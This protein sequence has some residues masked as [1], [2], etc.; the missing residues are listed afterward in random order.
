PGSRKQ[1]TRDIGTRAGVSRPRP[2]DQ[3][4]V[5]E[6]DFGAAGAGP[7]A[8]G[9]GRHAD[10]QARGRRVRHPGRKRGGLR[11]VHQPRA[12]GS[13][14]RERPQPVVRERQPAQGRR[15][16]R[17]ADRRT[18][19][20][21]TPQERLTVR[22][23]ALVALA[24]TLAACNRSDP[25]P[26]AVGTEDAAPSPSPVATDGAAGVN[27][28]SEVALALDAEGLRFV[29]N[30]TGSA[31]LVAFGAPRGQVE[32]AVQRATGGTPRRSTGEECP[33][34]PTEFTSFGELQLAFQD[35][36]WIGWALGGAFPA[37]T[38]DG[39]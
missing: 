1:G 19:R 27:T 18:A 34:G 8:R 26:R 21:A 12:R 6:R 9:T 14:G 25:P 16:Q 20:P 15:A 13:D 4:R 37:T 35:D 28:A 30:D 5:S 23:A 24:L 36:R 32:Q 2:G 10:R 17:G 3:H 39:I 11:D 22:R 31:S 38:M 7:H 29:A 33:A